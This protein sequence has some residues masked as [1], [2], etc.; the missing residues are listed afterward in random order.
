MHGRRRALVPMIL[1]ACAA[2]LAVP[3]VA[4][5]AIP[6]VFGGQVACAV[7]PDGVRFCGS[8]QPRSTV[9][10]FDGV[11]IDVNVAFPPEPA[12]G[13]DGG[14]PVIG[15]FHGYGGSK[16]GLSGMQP[17]LDR[18]Y[19]VFSM[20][21]RGFRESCGSQASK[22]ADPAG[23]ENGFVRL[24][25]TRYEIR[26]AQYFLGL[27]AD[28][29]LID[30]QRIGAIGPSYGGGISLALAAL[31][32]RVMLP[33]GQL[34]PWTSPGGKALQVAGAAPWI[35]WSDL[36][37]S[38]VPNGSTLD[39][40]VEN[41]YRG[42]FGVMKDSLV[43]GLYVS[44]LGS[45]GF[46]APVGTPGANITGWRDFL[47]AGEPYTNPQAQA[48]QDEFTDFHSSYYIDPS[49]EPAPIF[50]ANGFT[51]DLFPVD[52]VLRY[53]NRTITQYPDAKFQILAAEIAG[54]P[55][56]A[57]EPEVISQLIASQNEWLDFYVKG[58]GAEPFQGVK[59]ITQTCPADEPAGIQ[60]KADSWSQLARGELRFKDTLKQ[61]IA[62][63]SGN[64]EIAKAFD[65]VTGDGSCAEVE[66]ADE[67]GAIQMVLPPAPKPY[68]MIG[69]PT[70]IGKF[71]LPGDTSQVAARLLDVG[72]NGM[73]RLVARGLWRPETGGPSK[74]V[75]QMHPNGW[76]FDESHVPVLE[77]LAKDAGGGDFDS[78]GRPSNDQQKVTL[79]TLELRLPVRE[80]PGSLQGIVGSPAPR[81]VPKG[82]EL[83]EGFEVNDNRRAKL[84]GGNLGLEGSDVEA[85][86]K[87]PKQF[88]ACNAI[89]VK[90]KGETGTF[91][92]DFVRK[93]NGG[94]SKTVDLSLK[95][96]GR[97]WFE[98]HSKAKVT[99]TVKS[100]ETV[101]KFKADRKIKR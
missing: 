31:K 38:L 20:T 33:D 96:R 26:D 9:K 76:T 13:P 43:N 49:V 93:V 41:P 18:G 101:G 57:S 54:H 91:V 35:T 80:K 28:E 25:D 81:F 58:V 36:A 6:S 73:E 62:A 37:Y 60:Y 55:R 1:V 30:P 2:A 21:D 90:L 3:A 64:P 71:T 7:Q 97:E 14:Y 27:L 77:L 10:T 75:F 68:T 88:V 63:D 82:Y 48:I 87:C 15:S 39:Y 51:D 59:A 94:D 23:C 45:P 98:D 50:Y 29:N 40:A 19:A 46:Y 17:Y 32:N 52:E 72:P 85:K 16:T 65:P 12:S 11:P 34:V 86:V 74:Q 78:Y 100:P 99:A 53:Y 42:R 8:T 67:N 70:V 83:M 22:D 5:A 89:S 92:N 56:S 47:L 95:Q 84:G 79:E 4:S 66:T 44:G 61:S 69:S 24:D